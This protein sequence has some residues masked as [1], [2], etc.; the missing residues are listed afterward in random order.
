M[1]NGNF[2]KDEISK[3]EWEFGKKIGMNKQEQNSSKNRYSK[4]ERFC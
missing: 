2:N 3:K 1:P 4:T